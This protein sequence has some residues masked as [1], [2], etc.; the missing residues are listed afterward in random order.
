MPKF[1]ELTTRDGSFVY[2]NINCIM[3]VNPCKGGG[4][5]KTEVD[6]IGGPDDYRLVK[7]TY[8]EVIALIQHALEEGNK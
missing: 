1:V 8:H 7:E 3:Q 5:E 2:I 6:L 4:V